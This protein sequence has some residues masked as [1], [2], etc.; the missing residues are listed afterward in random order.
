[1]AISYPLSAPPA[2][3]ASERISLITKF[4][5]AE[6]PYTGAQST[7][8]TGYSQWQVSIDFPPL[9]RAAAKAFMAWLDRMQGPYGTFTYQPN[10][11]G[12]ALSGRT[13]SAAANAMTNNINVTGWSAGQASGL[14]AGDYVTIGSQMFRITV[15]PANADGSGICALEVMPSVRNTIASGTA[16]NFATPTVTLRLADSG[17]GNTGGSLMTTPDAITVPS[18]NCIEAR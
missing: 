5:Y 10:G 16:C 9:S 8:T 7:T 1:M 11:S 15:A 4:N 12:V 3:P 18:L 13:L 17:S 14:S 6:S 2:T